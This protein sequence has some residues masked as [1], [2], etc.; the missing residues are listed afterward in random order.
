MFSQADAPPFHSWR[1]AD[2]PDE[3]RFMI[4][5]ICSQPAHPRGAQH[6]DD[7]AQQE[8]SL[9]RCS[10]CSAEHWQP[11]VHPGSGYYESEAMALY[12]R[13]HAADRPG[14]LDPRHAYFLERFGQLEGQSVLD[15]GCGNGSF[16]VRLGARRDD[17]WGFDIDQR[18]VDVA[19]AQGLENVSRSTAAEFLAQARADDVWFDTIVAFDVVE[20][21][22]DPRAFLEQ[23]LSRLSPGGRFFMTVPNRE[24]LLAATMKVDLPPHHFFRFDAQSARHLLSH[25]GLEHV[26]AETFQYGYA[27]AAALDWLRRTV[28]GLAASRGGAKNV[29][30]GARGP[31]R[32]DRSQLG[33]SAKLLELATS[34]VRLP[35]IVCERALGRG[36]KLAATGRAPRRA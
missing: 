19:R 32:K 3:P 35:S 23:L 4:C 13:L 33:R 36:F 27:G 6:R 30:P 22:T 10:G 17:L 34:A 28:K 26:E 21:V 20:H 14:Q 8:Y 18:S 5:P 25:A 9:Y 11:L 2:G 1:P 24:R 31:V 12:T 29:T 7:T 15:A 16:L